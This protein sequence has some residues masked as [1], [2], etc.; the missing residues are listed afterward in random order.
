MGD[1]S[2]NSQI[3]DALTQMNSVLVGNSS[4][5]SLAIMNAVMADTMGMAMHNAVSAQHNAQ[6]IGG[7]SAT[8]ACARMLG[9][10]SPPPAPDKPTPSENKGSDFFDC[11]SCNVPKGKEKNKDKESDSRL[12]NWLSGVFRDHEARSKHDTHKEPELT[13]QVPPEP[14]EAN[15]G[16]PPEEE[17]PPEPETHGKKKHRI[18]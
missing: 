10:M 3:T 16:H 14:E 17:P 11:S 6:M 18:F 12:K 4:P 8:S 7:A 1:R 15:P 2:V 9:T 13:G 5:Q